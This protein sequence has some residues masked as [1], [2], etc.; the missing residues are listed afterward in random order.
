M[1]L[2]LFTGSTKDGNGHLLE[3]LGSARIAGHLARMVRARLHRRNHV[4]CLAH[5]R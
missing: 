4:V 5:R 3:R 2:T 1:P